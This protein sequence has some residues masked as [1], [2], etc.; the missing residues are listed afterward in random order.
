MLM[1]KQFFFVKWRILFS[2]NFFKSPYAI[3]RPNM[4]ELV[5]V[6]NYCIL[7]LGISSLGDWTSL[8]FPYDYKTIQRD[9]KSSNL[10]LNEAV[11]MAQ[12]HPL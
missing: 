4:T 2:V 3:V 10:S 7:F 12:N 5:A 1:L 9:L 8:L 11:D 6:I